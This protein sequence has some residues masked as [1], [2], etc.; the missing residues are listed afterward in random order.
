MARRRLLRT[1]MNL[2]SPQSI[3]RT[4]NDERA[5][6]RHAFQ[7]GDN[8]WEHLERAHIL[9]QPW[10]VDHVAVHAAMLAQAWRDRDTIELRGQ[11]VRLMVAGPGSMTRR[12]PVGN[13]GRARVPATSPMTIAD[14]E[15]RAALLASGQPVD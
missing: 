12:Y 7:S 15:V 1:A 11:L 4:I 5:A 9:S 10:P 2:R 3:R 8:G 14:I 13:T 6:A